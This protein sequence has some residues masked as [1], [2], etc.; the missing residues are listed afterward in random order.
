M[1]MF[2]TKVV[3]EIKASSLCA[4]IFFPKK[5]PFM[6]KNGKTVRERQTTDDKKIR[7]GRDA[8]FMPD[9]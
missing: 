5:V 8:S 2:Q 1:R 3:Y 6:R 9:T 4:I 7:H